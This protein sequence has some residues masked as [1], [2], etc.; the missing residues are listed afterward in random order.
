MITYIALL[1]GVNVSGQKKIKMADL[2]ALMVKLGLKDVVTYIQSGNL[3]FS[4]EERK[5]QNLEDKI[6]KAITNSFGFDV[7]VLVKTKTEL[8][9]IL[10]KSPYSKKEDLEAK[11]IY[12][13]LLKNAPEGESIANL[14]Q[15]DYPN[16]LFS[17]SNKC[18]Y[19]NCLNGAGKAKLTNNIIERK[20]KVSATTRNH[21]TMVKLLELADEN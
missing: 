3:V 16:E 14:V 12:Y 13:V 6:K 4:S 2:E 8:E 19:L 15:E 1:R 21:R 17:I 5:L 20:L 11:R 10:K 18:V 7:P 9:D